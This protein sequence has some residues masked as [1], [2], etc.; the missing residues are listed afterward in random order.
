MKN[1][2]IKKC[3]SV[4]LSVCVWFFL[5]PF[6]FL[7]GPQRWVGSVIIVHEREASD[8]LWKGSLLFRCIGEERIGT[9]QEILYFERKTRAG[10]GSFTWNSRWRCWWTGSVHVCEPHTH[11]I[12]GLIT[13]LHVY[14]PSYNMLFVWASHV[15][16]KFIFIFIFIFFALLSLRISHCSGVYIPPFSFTFFFSY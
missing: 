8:L 5:Y 2:I 15:R 16:S 11:T 13:C 14:W 3:K 10:V 7:I 1:I 9:V 6:L 4:V 12:R